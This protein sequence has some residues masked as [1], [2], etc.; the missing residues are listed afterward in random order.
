MPK[1]KGAI[2]EKDLTKGDLRILNA[3]RKSI[4]DDLGDEAFAKW[5]AEGSAGEN[6]TDP[7]IALIESALNPLMDKIRI[8][9]GSAYAL[10]RGRRQ[11]IVEPVDLKG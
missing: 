7:N 1:A 4:G 3:L 5:Y 8:P 6:G 9:R 11:F 2:S 10:R